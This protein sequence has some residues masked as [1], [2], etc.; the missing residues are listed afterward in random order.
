[1][2]PV[3]TTDGGCETMLFDATGQCL[4]DRVQTEEQHV[5]RLDEQQRERG[6]EH[7]R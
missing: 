1:M 4:E 3:R 6:V 5:G 2:N 7:V